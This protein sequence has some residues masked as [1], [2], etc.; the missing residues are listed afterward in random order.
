M[1]WIYSMIYDKEKR[2]IIRLYDQNIEQI[3]I[4]ITFS[5]YDKYDSYK[6]SL[7]LNFFL[8]LL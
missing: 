6:Y 2:Y 7:L 1:G 4:I 8:V 3:F 5:V